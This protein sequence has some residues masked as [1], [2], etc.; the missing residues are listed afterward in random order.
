VRVDQL[1]P[2]QWPPDA[3]SRNECEGSIVSIV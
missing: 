2:Y 3:A 1:L